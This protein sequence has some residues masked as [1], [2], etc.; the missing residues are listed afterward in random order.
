ML[1]CDTFW[2]VTSYSGEF[3]TSGIS[4]CITVNTEAEHYS[5]K[6]SIN[7][8]IRTL[9]IRIS[10]YPDRLGSSDR[11]VGN[12]TKLTCLEITGYR[13]EYKKVWWLLELQ[14]RRDRKVYTQV[15]TVNSNSRT[16][17]CQCSLFSKK[18]PII[19]IFCI[20]GSLVV[21][22]S[23]DKWSSTARRSGRHELRGIHMKE[24]LRYLSMFCV[25]F[26]TLLVKV[27]GGWR[28]SKKNIF[29][30]RNNYYNNL[31]N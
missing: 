17:K 14:I 3:Q 25:L 5:V 8:F 28:F 26:L 12:S 6:Y 10:N 18:N 27:S 11:F 16:S 29:S 1:R 20:T 9:V 22:V 13:I 21:P 23:Q 15:H 31:Q 30:Q 7:P 2:L 24:Y 19:R 4:F